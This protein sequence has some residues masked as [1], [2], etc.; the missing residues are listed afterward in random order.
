[1]Q[2]YLA[3]LV[4]KY[5]DAGLKIFA[6]GLFA[7]ETDDKMTIW[8]K[9]AKTP[10]FTSGVSWFIVRQLKIYSCICHRFRSI[11]AY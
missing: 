5:L 9:I 7:H 4:A 10:R 1:M 2:Y 6:G 11:F 3:I 8:D